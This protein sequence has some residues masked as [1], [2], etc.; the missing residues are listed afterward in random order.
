MANVDSP[1]GLV[2]TKHKS[3]APYNNSFNYY[4]IPDTEASALFI[5]DPVI[6]T[7][8]ANTTSVGGFQA[9]TLPEVTKASFGATNRISGVIVGFQ[10]DVDTNLSRIFNPATTERVVFVAD[11]PDLS[12]EVQDD[13]SASLDATAIG[14]N[15]NLVDGTGSTVTG[16]SGV[17]LDATTP[18]ADATFQLKIE[19]LIPREDN[20]LGT[21][22]KLEVTIN[23]H[24]KSTGVGSAGV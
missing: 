10:A 1:K 18:A 15:A 6:I 17:E 23:L 16:L 22:S 9:G 24:T 7:G 3:G 19:R 21:N 20:E 11:D 2:P 5:G 4:Y 13:G 12:F 14:A 8:T